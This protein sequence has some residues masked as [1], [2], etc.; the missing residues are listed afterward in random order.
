M[1][2][3]PIGDRVIVRPDVPDE[4]TPSGIIIPDMAKETPQRGTIVAVGEGELVA[5]SGLRTGDAVVYAKFAGTT[6]DADD[7]EVLVLGFRDVIAKV[8]S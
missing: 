2:L 3:E 1:N 4:M 5:A 6:I 7:G 8:R